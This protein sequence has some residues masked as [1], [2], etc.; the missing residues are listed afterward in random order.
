L[1]HSGVPAFKIGKALPG[2]LRPDKLVAYLPDFASLARTAGTLQKAIKEYPAQGVPFTAPI[3]AAGFLS[4]GMDP[5]Q[6]VTSFD[7]E[8]HESWRSWLTSQ[9]AIAILE[10]KTAAEIEPW[11][12]AL[13]RLRLE[14]IDTETWVPKQA[15][16]QNARREK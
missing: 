6:D 13:D 10:V 1:T 3:D 12:Y 7:R 15:L 4:W 5:P 8:R 11:Q 9:L 2:V 14:G 16:W